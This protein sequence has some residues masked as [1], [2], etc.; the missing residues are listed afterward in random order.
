[1]PAAAGA[2]VAGVDADSR[3]VLQHAELGG[4]YSAA[5]TM[6]FD[7]VVA[8]SQLRDALLNAMR[9]TTARRQLSVRPLRRPGVLP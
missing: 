8:P 3:A 2:D 5:D 9:L 1:M 7:E 4:A 6:S